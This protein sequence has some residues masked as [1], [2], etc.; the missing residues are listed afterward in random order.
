MQISIV[1]GY[2]R[3][4]DKKNVF[5]WAANQRMKIICLI[6]FVFLY[7]RVLYS[8]EARK[9]YFSYEQRA[10]LSLTNY[11]V[12]WHITEAVCLIKKGEA[13]LISRKPCNRSYWACVTSHLHFLKLCLK[14]LFV[15]VLPV[16][17]K[18]RHMILW[19]IKCYQISLS[20]T[21]EHQLG[22]K[23]HVQS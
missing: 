21:I 4:W 16:V 14:V 20:F 11:I 5:Q 3:S 1:C 13:K 23:I 10:F 12:H 22:Y 17:A 2:I 19:R 7:K 18:E 8:A 15:R 9:M 6:A